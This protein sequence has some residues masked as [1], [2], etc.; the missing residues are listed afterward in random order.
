MPDILLVE[1]IQRLQQLFPQQ[2]ICIGADDKEADSKSIWLRLLSKF[3]KC[4]RRK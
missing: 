1:R 3:L 2:H 4:M